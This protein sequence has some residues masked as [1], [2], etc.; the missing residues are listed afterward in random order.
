MAVRGTPSWLGDENAA[1]ALELLLQHGPQSR[2]GLS[3]LSGLSKQTA[4]QIVSRLVDRD[5]IEPVGEESP[6]RGPSAIVYG[7]RST[8]SYA[9][10]INI[11]QQ[12]VQS[13]VVDVLG[14]AHPIVRQDTAALDRERS[15]ARDVATAVLRA[16]E[17]AEVDLAAVDQ[18]CIG[19]PSSVDPR[20]D[21]LSSVEA[22]PGWSRTSVRQQLETALGCSVRVD[23]DANLAVV[24]ERRAGHFDPAATL[25][26]IWVGYGIGLAL[27]IGGTILRGAA[28]GAGEIGHLPISYGR[29]GVDGGQT[30]LEDLVGATGLER[31]AREIAE[32]D[33]SFD[34]ILAD[35]A[36]STRMIEHLAPRLALGITPVLGVVD[37][38]LII[39]GGPVGQAGGVRL[40]EAIREAIRNHTR[41]D[42]SILLS[43]V[44]ADP[45]LT[46][47]ANLLLT[48]LRR[49]LVE[50]ARTAEHEDNRSRAIESRLRKIH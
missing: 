12:G 11:D 29:P 17:A 50:R 6:T 20:S 41:W 14:A 23:N 16:C 38:E 36:L 5:L 31:L 44:T 46:G 26:L 47:A 7:V 30:D 25:A 27:D 34:A 2:N 33:F 1:S 24:A 3:G 22:L 40:T 19:V 49:T 13:Q 39:I 48:D 9:V 28:G 45:V 4:A 32:P 10:A 21:E 15:A 37:P 18:V 35:Q 8:L 42:P 43:R